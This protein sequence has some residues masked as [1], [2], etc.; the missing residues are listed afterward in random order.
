MKKEIIQIKNEKHGQVGET[1]TWFVGT[2]I[3]LV[4]LI[5]GIYIVNVGGIIKGL[6][7]KSIEYKSDT[8][9][10]AEISLN[11][12]LLTEQ[13]GELIYQTLKR[14]GNLN[15]NNGPLAEKIFRELY[16]KDY[17]E[18]WFGM[19]T[20]DQG[21]LDSTYNGK[22]NDYFGGKPRTAVQ[23]PDGTPYIKDFWFHPRW[24]KNNEYISLFF[25]GKQ[26]K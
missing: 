9:R 3:V 7:R 15:L 25:V 22:D 16:K 26:V 12:Y 14:E 2:L 11:S 4:I 21:I 17:Q 19:T 10:L 24:T 18:I 13:N 8:D 23:G 5:V 1:L 6:D 20:L